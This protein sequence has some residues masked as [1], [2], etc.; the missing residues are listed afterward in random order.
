LWGWDA[1][2]QVNVPAKS[3]LL[4]STS[5]KELQRQTELPNQTSGGRDRSFSLDSASREL[6]TKCSKGLTVD[7]DPGGRG[8]SMEP[9]QGSSDHLSRPDGD[10]IGRAH[11]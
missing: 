6:L 10:E 4:R 2:V 8:L 7:S 9:I 3:E 11:V 1:W 5:E